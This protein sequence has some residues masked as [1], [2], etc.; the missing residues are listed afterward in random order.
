M[1]TSFLKIENRP[2]GPVSLLLAKDV[3]KEK[4]GATKF[5]LRVQASQNRI[6]IFES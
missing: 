5:R 2:S 3:A 6:S 1:C 4:G